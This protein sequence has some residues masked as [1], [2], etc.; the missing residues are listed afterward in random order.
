MNL[1]DQKKIVYTAQSKKYFF[2]R[3]LICKYVLE[4]DAVPINPFNVWGYFL[5]ELTDR[6]LVRR[7]NNNIIRISDEVWIFGPIAD[8][9]LFEIE[10]AMKLSKKI[11][12]FSLGSSSNSINHIDINDIEIEPEAL[13][14]RSKEEIIKNIKLYM[15]NFD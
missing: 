13:L 4:N 10:Y 15:N 1:T 6:N 7:G 2:A 8:G 11:K 14:E 12:F 5:Y 9:V 3:M